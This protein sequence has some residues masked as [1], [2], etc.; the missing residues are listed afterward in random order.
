[1]LF[2]ITTE[3]QHRRNCCKMSARLVKIM[4]KEYILLEALS[5][6][7]GILEAGSST[8]LSRVIFHFIND[9]GERFEHTLRKRAYDIDV[10]CSYFN[11]PQVRKNKSKTALKSCNIELKCF[12]PFFLV[13]SLRSLPLS[14][15]GRHRFPKQPFKELVTDLHLC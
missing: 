13:L 11:F 5:P 2:Q 9:L 12:T 14:T 3:M 1:M 6:A 8:D 15:S 10:T 7:G 4:Q